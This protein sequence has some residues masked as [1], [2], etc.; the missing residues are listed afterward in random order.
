MNI[1]TRTGAYVDLKELVD[2]NKDLIKFSIAL[3][4]LFDGV[5]QSVRELEKGWNDSKIIEFKA[6][7]NTYTKKLE[8][9][10]QELRSYSKFSEE[11]WIPLI[12]R[13]LNMKRT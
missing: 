13:H 1:K 5:E 4:K 12:E 8:P 7:F 11:H 10:A 9:L 6:D 3:E 2:F